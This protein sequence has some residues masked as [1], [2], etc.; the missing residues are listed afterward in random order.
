[1]I[2]RPRSFGK[3]EPM[4]RQAV[5]WRA[6]TCTRWGVC[7]T[8][9][10]LLAG[11]FGCGQSATALTAGAAGNATVP[12]ADE[13]AAPKGMAIADP[14]LREAREQADALLQDLLQ[15]NF[16]QDENL[17]LVA[18][19]VKGYTS[20]SVQSQAIAGKGKAEFKGTLSGPAGKAH[21]RMLL[22]KQAA[23]QWAVGIFS[24]PN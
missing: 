24:G 17:A 13:T 2:Q 10:I 19:K 21:F 9:G 11:A 15:G 3:Q 8:A 12:S 5:D 20:W 4:Q 7:C 6:K 16:D 18:E 1:L 14:V 22:V 23:G